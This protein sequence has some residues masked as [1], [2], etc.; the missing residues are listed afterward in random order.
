MHTVTVKL[1]EPPHR[2][3]TQASAQ[4]HVSKSEFI[5]RALEIYLRERQ[6]AGSLVSALD[7][8]DDL[9]GCFAGGPEDLSSNPYHLSLFGRA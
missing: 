1:P 7:Q 6:A 5:R 2:A 9:V 4:E 3:L 8:A